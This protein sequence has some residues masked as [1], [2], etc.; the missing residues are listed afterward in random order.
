MRR[1]LAIGLAI[2]SAAA[3][4]AIAAPASAGS[5]RGALPKTT[6]AAD[7]RWL[8]IG[9]LTWFEGARQYVLTR[10][11][12]ETGNQVG[13]SRT[14]NDGWDP[15]GRRLVTLAAP[16]DGLTM[17]LVPAVSDAG[18]LSTTWRAP[19]CTDPV[20]DRWF[21][22]YD[23][24]GAP[25][26]T[27]VLVADA[28]RPVRPLGDG[29]W[30]TADEIGTL[31]WRGPDGADRTALPQS[32]ST[33]RGAAVDTDGRLLL[34]FDGPSLTRWPVGGPGVG[35]LAL[36]TGCPF[37]AASAVGPAPDGGFATACQMGSPPALTV[38]RYTA[39]G[40]VAWQ[41]V[42]TARV[43]PA[44]CRT[45]LGFDRPTHVTVD[46]LDRV[47]VAGGASNSSFGQGIA[48]ESFTSTGP[49]PIAD[50][51]FDEMHGPTHSSADLRLAAPD[52]VVYAWVTSCC[53][54]LEQPA[55]TSSTAGS[56]LA[57]GPPGAPACD[58]DLALGT[59][60]ESAL[61]GTVLRCASPQIGREPTGY[62]IEARDL[63]GALLGSDAI[64]PDDDTV[65]GPF[66]VETASSTGGQVVKMQVVPFNTHGDGTPGPV[67]TAIPP[68]AS[69]DAFVQRQYA[70]LTV[71]AAPGPALIDE[72]RSGSKTPQSVVVDL[73]AGGHAKADVEPVARLYRA[74]FLRDADPSGLA[75]WVRRHRNG[76]SLS[77]IAGQF[78]SSPEFTRRYGSLSN[79][80]F[81][82]LL[83]R[84]V[85][86]RPADPSGAAFWTKRLDTRRA[87]RGSVVLGFSESTES[88]R[89]SAPLVQPLAAAFLL[90]GRLPT[91]AEQADWAGAADPRAAAVADILRSAGYADRIDA[92]A[93]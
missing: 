39:A 57:P 9:P 82:A 19:G 72:V 66:A 54:T 87:S 76:Q 73:L 44:C 92:L 43:G 88:I 1:M 80:A 29:S 35:S 7:E 71:A 33:V 81:V 40:D 59:L 4:L 68:F 3:L 93:G 49:G 5:G 70:D 6:A 85:F 11:D 56:G 65:P 48:L 50:F 8:T 58:V 67:A 23:A 91:A 63:H 84:N 16:A 12:D 75:Y 37:G 79:A 27:P 90:L 89:R 22:R 30:L 36:F 52:H 26:G 31:G 62:R 18:I 24:T 2:T 32:I 46:A 64:G 53:S 45:P 28:P 74:F 13:I 41:S 69:V 42:G 25:V 15:S 78:A 51:Q 60:D 20:C 17:E 14:P 10:Y 38:T 55:P 34:T 47:W 83:Y 77:R 61:A 86:G 21:A